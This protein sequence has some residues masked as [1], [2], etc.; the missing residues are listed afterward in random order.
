MILIVFQNW[1]QWKHPIDVFRLKKQILSCTT[2][3]K[4]SLHE[5]RK[6]EIKAHSPE[7]YL[8]VKKKKKVFLAAL[9]YLLQLKPVSSAILLTAFML[10]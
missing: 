3:L 7:F 6:K 10:A 5:L 2:I 1:Y 8:C 9:G 4:A